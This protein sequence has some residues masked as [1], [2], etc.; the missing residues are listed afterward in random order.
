LS[1]LCRDCEAI[2]QATGGLCALCRSRRIVSHAELETLAIAHLDCDAFYAS[3]EKRDRPELR[4]RPLIVGGGVR[5]VVTTC[6]YVARTFGV[7][8]AM[9]MF[10]AKA[11]CPEAVILPPDFP[12]YRAESQRIMAA[13]RA[14]TPLVEPLSL[15]EAWLDL[16]GT[17]RLHGAPASV[18]L[19]RLQG[20]IEREV[21][22]AVSIGLA[23]AKFLAKIASDLDKPRGY[24]VI[25]KA[26]AK[27]FLGPRPV[28][29]LP[30]VGPVFAQGLARAGFATVGDLARAD[31]RDLARRFG[32]A[33]PRLASLAQ[34]LDARRVDPVSPRKS[35]S[36]ETTFD[37]DLASIIELEDRL[38]PLCETVAR[39]AR[40]ESSAGGV[41][42]LKLRRPD[43]Q[44]VT[45]R[46]SLDAPTQTAKALFAASRALLREEGS[47]GAYRLIG[48][49]LSDLEPAASGADDLFGGSESRA[50]IGERTGDSLRQRFGDAVLV[51]GRTFGAGAKRPLPR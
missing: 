46:H 25:G 7:R 29:I 50:L 4:D 2:V 31:V 17:A 26:E 47:G 16:S 19:S 10:R 21:G 6:C 45:R 33:G 13:M 32:V 23:P 35:I 15:D 12:K 18:V 38:W 48:V 39:R 28:S 30:G 8:S 5:G 9:P 42:T 34:G 49:G 20:R 36:A 43:F 44:I 27:S 51:S 1:T 24:A 40:A 11:L 14:L 3:V 22:I 37:E 41:V